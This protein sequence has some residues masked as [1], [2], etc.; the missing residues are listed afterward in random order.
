MFET[1]F[2]ML[3][4][5]VFIKFFSFD[6]LI[7]SSLIRF[8]YSFH[9]FSES[10]LPAEQE[11]MLSCLTGDLAPLPEDLLESSSE[12][13][14]SDLFE[15]IYTFLPFLLC[16]LVAYYINSPEAPNKSLLLPL[17]MD[18]LALLLLFLGFEFCRI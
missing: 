13:S 4:L 8:S 5:R 10:M 2:L 17:P 16:I 7:F 18:G 12:D 9:L 11:E 6:F 3:F 14:E 15:V 1:I